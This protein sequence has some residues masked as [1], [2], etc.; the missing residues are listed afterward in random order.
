MA[1]KAAL[2]T[3][4][5]IRHDKLQP[6]DFLPKQ[7]LFPSAPYSGWTIEQILSAIDSHDQGNFQFS[8]LLYHAMTKQAR[9]GAALDKRAHF[10]RNFPFHLELDKDA[11]IRI[12]KMAKEW[13]KNYACTLS[14]DTLSEIIRRTVM[15]GFC[16]A[17]HSYRVEFD[18]I[19]PVIDVWSQSSCYYNQMDRKFYVSSKQ[20]EMLKVD[21][22]PW[23][24]FSTGGMRPWLNG[25]IR[26]LA[27]PFFMLINAQYRWTEFNDVEAEAFKYVTGPVQTRI[28]DEAGKLV[29]KISLS[30]A[31]D[32]V[33]LP[34]GY[35][36]KLL[37]S[38]GRGSV[39]KTFSD[40]IDQCN[41]DISIV[42][43]G[44]NLVQEISGGSHAAATAA[45]DGLYDLAK[46]DASM[47][48]P[49]YSDTSRLWIEKNF[50]PER[51]GE[52]S[53]TQFKPRPVWDVRKPDDQKEIALTAASYSA[54]FSQF[55]Q[56]AGPEIIQS[57][58][59]DWVEQAKRCGIAIKQ[60][61][62]SSKVTQNE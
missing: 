56:S 35:D 8:E 14:D 42:L 62:I 30:R 29:S 55:L 60:E 40:L 47:L 59:I 1:K 4:A 53:L 33:F 21:G 22:D 12:N 9:I 48:H 6:Y 36:F 34:E 38:Q 61:D 20:G 25:A 39:H 51:Y 32:T 49:L 28:Q 58:P 7:E 43:L 57:L 5:N 50:T 15:F 46:A 44:N 16:I 10:I 11:P 37:A 3:A 26:K 54:S 19:V 27:F 23:I 13:E 17:R 52:M 2:K 45:F 41:K 31:G 18:Q 24:V